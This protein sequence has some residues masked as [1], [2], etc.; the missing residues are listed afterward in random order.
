MEG[1]TPG[2]PVDLCRDDDEQHTM[3]L[4]DDD[5]SQAFR[6]LLS[7]ELRQQLAHHEAR[8]AAAARDNALREAARERKAQEQKFR[9][10]I[11]A[12]LLPL[13]RVLT[14]ERMPTKCSLVQE[15]RRAIDQLREIR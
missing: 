15:T 13:S 8:L 1:S 9:Q 7:P 6:N 14:D 5:A 3:Q 10:Q 12:A 4:A 11:L 2:H